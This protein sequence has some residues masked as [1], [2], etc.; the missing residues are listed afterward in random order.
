VANDMH[1]VEVVNYRKGR[2]IV[3]S[4]NFEIA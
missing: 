4:D 3:K 2:G 1:I